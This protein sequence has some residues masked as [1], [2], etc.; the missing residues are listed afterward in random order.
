MSEK[1]EDHYEVLLFASYCG[2]ANPI[3]TDQKPCQACLGMSNVFKIPK[4]ALG[5]YVRELA[6]EWNEHESVN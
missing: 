2:N 3:C 1:T 5:E 6:P 4:E